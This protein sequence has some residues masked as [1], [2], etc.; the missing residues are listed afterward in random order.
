MTGVRWRP[1]R[2]SLVLALGLRLWSIDHGLPFVYN[3]DE[4]LHFVP[5]AVDMFGGSF[6]PRYFENPP[7]LTYLFYLVFGCASASAGSRRAASRRPR[8]RVRDGADGGGA[9]RHAVVGFV[10]WAGPRWFDRASACVAA[11]IMATAFLPVFYSKL[12]LNDVVTMAPVALA[13]VACL[14]VWEQ[15][16]WA[17]GAGRRGRGRRHRD[18]VHGGR[19]ARGARRRCLLRFLADSGELR[20]ACSACVA[21]GVAFGLAFALLNPFALIDLLRVR[22]RSAASRAGERQARPGGRARLALLPV[23]VH[24]GARRAARAGRLAGGVLCC[25]ATGGAGSLLLAFPLFLFLF[26]GA[27]ARFFGRWLLPVYP[28]LCVLAGYARVGAAE[29]LRAPRAAAR[30]AVVLLARCARRAS[31][32]PSTSTACSAARTRARGA[33]AGSRNVPAGTAWWWSRSCRPAS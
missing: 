22:A 32:R 25:G 13:L 28:A 31:C 8:V 18:E 6:N 2:A 26:L 4:E 1:G 24:L 7:A 33:S 21:A 20:R 30:R 15:G 5:V 27:Q 14:L 29:Q 9:H 12:A 11:A 3:A 16:R 19:D 23:D 17:L 10:Y